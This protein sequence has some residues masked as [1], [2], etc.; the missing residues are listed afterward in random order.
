MS[1]KQGVVQGPQSSERSLT[2]GDPLGSGASSRVWA[3]L[4]TGDSLQLWLF[5]AWELGRK[6]GQL[7]PGMGKEPEQGKESR[8]RGPQSVHDPRA[9]EQTRRVSWTH[10]G[11]G[12]AHASFRGHG[13]GQHC[14]S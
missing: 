9:S 13:L 10:E 3:R 5:L 2:R 14:L 1:G 6:S 12:G 8:R 4:W 7:P 11:G